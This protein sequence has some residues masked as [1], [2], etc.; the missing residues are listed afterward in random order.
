[1]DTQRREMKNLFL[2]H[3]Q[4]KAPP[5]HLFSRTTALNTSMND[6]LHNAEAISVIHVV[7]QSCMCNIMCIPAKS[8][9]KKLGN[10]MHDT[11]YRSKI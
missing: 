9:S 6:C 4:G 2:S 3:H 11:N 8:Y 1:M 10:Y 7:Y 5:S